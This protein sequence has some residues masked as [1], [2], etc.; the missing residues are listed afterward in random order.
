[1]RP[2]SRRVR[3]RWRRGTPVSQTQGSCRGLRQI[4]CVHGI[5]ANVSIKLNILLLRVKKKTFLKVYRRCWEVDTPR[6]HPCGIMR[7]WRRVSVFGKC[8]IPKQHKVE[9]YVQLTFSFVHRLN[10]FGAKC[11]AL[12]CYPVTEV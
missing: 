3:R 8:E 11:F 9:D 6:L 2:A 12:S 7:N 1:M 10:H 4:S 5:L